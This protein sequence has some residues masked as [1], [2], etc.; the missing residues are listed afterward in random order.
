MP[1][2]W[3][4]DAPVDHG[5]RLPCAGGRRRAAEKRGS[6]TTARPERSAMLV[7]PPAT[8]ARRARSLR[9]VRARPARVRRCAAPGD[10]GAWIVANVASPVAA[11]NLVADEVRATYDV[12]LPRASG[13]SAHD[14]SA[15]DH[16][17]RRRSYD[18]PG[19]GGRAAGDPAG[20][21][22]PH[23]EDRQAQPRPGAA[24]VN[25]RDLRLVSVMVNEPVL[26]TTGAAS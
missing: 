15:R 23:R 1:R 21:D 13:R 12:S 3:D 5:P 10:G 8:T 25:P 16:R 19:A 18:D 4:L 2:R 17:S 7:A 9:P 22:A 20:P 14:V 24:A 26:T 11:Y 6:V